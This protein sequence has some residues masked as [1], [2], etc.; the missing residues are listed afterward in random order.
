[1]MFQEWVRANPLNPITALLYH[2]LLL[3]NNWFETS[4]LS[5]PINQYKNYL[6]M[7]NLLNF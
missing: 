1:M 7:E 4:V 3:D 5:F 6:H 2:R